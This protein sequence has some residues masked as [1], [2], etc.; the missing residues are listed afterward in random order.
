[1]HRE[2]LIKMRV[3]GFSK[4]V[5]CRCSIKKKINNLEFRFTLTRFWWH[6][7]VKNMINQNHIQKGPRAENIKLILLQE[8]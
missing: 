5:K 7:K 6:G 3:M 2:W 8:V 1:M 4:C